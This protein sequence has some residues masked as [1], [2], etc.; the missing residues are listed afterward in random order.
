MKCLQFQ[1][2]PNLGIKFLEFFK[3][4]SR[5]IENNFKKSHTNLFNKLNK[6]N[7]KV[8]KFV[9]KLWNA[10]HLEHQKIAN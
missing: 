7:N 9:Q 8:G 1:N 3:L 4:L 10:I 6:W 2:A 5:M